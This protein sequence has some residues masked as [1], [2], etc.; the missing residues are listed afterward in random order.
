MPYLYHIKF[1]LYPTS[2]TEPSALRTVYLPPPGE[3]LFRTPLPAHSIERSS[4]AYSGQDTA[5]NTLS[6]TNRSETEPR[7]DALLLPE[8]ST[9]LRDSPSHALAPLKPPNSR[10]AADDWRYGAV[11]IQSIDMELEATVDGARGKKS[12]TSKER[13]H[14]GLH[15]KARYVPS[16]TKTTDVGWGIVHLYRDSQETAGLEDDSTVT[17]RNSHGQ[18]ESGSFDIEDCT[19]LC[20]VAVPLFWLP[21][22][23]LSFVGPDAREN[24]S[25]FRLIRT[26]RTNKYMVL[27]KF[28]HAKKAKAWQRAWN[29]RLFAMDQSENCHVVFVKS[30][31]FLTPNDKTRDVSSFPHNTNDPFT[32]AAHTS[33][34]QSSKPLAPPTPSL[35]ELPTCPV[36]LERMDET[37]GLLTILCQ[38]VFHCACLEKWRG[39]GCP[40][41]RYTQSPSFTF[42]FP[43]PSNSQSHGHEDQ[44][45]ACSVCATNSNLWICLICGN[46]GCGRYDEKHAFEHYEQ[47]SHCYAMDIT[48]QHVWD[49]AGDGYVH[50][51]IQNK[52]E[53]STGSGRMVDLPYSRHPNAAFRAEGGDSVPREKMESMANEYTYL[54]TSQLEGQ[55]RYFEEQLERAVDKASQAGTRAEEAIRRL[56]REEALRNE[57]A[58]LLAQLKPSL[59]A[60]QARADRAEQKASKFEKLAREMGAQFRAEQSMNEG[61]LLRIHAAEDK[62]RA[63]EQESAGLREQV[64]ELTELNRDLSGF[65]SAQERVRELQAA[66][67]EVGEGDVSLPEPAPSVPS[68][69]GKKKG[70]RAKR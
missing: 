4:W 6:P 69:T 67:E 66:G 13:P 27:M 68:A 44:E 65:I 5:K 42:P 3:D 43:R 8:R 26:E 57:H 60:A 21:S 59:T 14:N 55:R 34:S 45:P 33:T 9:L 7:A 38:H 51:L 23:L 12:T 49:Y 64:A 61:L 62:A 54:L 40:V 25:H 39:S 37:T 11:S 19:T 53:T 1:E 36:C 20:I 16:D 41:C 29:G 47:T 56:D 63:A 46:T 70:K 50:R 18:Q 24:V 15:T 32:L 17:P 10:Q 48:S 58:D 22:D 30:V 52:S 2:A 35:V 28:R 31:E